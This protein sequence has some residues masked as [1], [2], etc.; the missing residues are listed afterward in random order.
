MATAHAILAV[1][2]VSMGPVKGLLMAILALFQRTLKD[3][4]APEFAL[5]MRRFLRVARTHPLNHGLVRTS[6]LAPIIALALLRGSAGGPESVFVLAGLLAFVAGSVSVWQFFA[7]SLYNVY[8][9]WEV[10]SPPVRWQRAYDRYFRLN[11][12]RGRG[13]GVAFVLFWPACPWP[14]P[15]EVQQ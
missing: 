7:P 6:L 4:T 1:A 14:N 8:L 9:G 10:E 15:E 3:L 12:I 13:P 5:V 11:V 2:A